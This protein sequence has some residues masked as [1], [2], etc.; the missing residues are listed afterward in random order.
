MRKVTGANDRDSLLSPPKRQVFEIA[1]LAGCPRVFR[2]DVEVSVEMH[3][4]FVSAAQKGAGKSRGP[5]WLD[6]PGLDQ[7][8]SA[9]QLQIYIINQAPYFRRTFSAG[10]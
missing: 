8:I 4:G 7:V 6:T 3:V 5:P 2:V 9:K 10:T 1:I